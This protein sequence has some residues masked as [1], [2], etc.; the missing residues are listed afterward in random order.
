MQMILA[1]AAGGAIGAVL[2]HLSNGAALHLLGPDFPYGTIGVNILG[3][4]LMGLLIATF[5]HIWQPDQTVKAFLI[6]GLLGAFT[7]F[8]TFSLDVIT[9]YERGALLAAAT[10]IGV[11]VILSIAGLFAGLM[12]VRQLSS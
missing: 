9:L 4:F 1:I 7:T 6:V 12:L 8:S 2:R 5:A 3:S 10:Y 11:S